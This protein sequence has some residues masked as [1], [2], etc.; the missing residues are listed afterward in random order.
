MPKE[1]ITAEKDIL[2]LQKVKLNWGQILNFIKQK[3]MSVATF[4][5]GAE[6]VRID[7]GNLIIGFGPSSVFHKESLDYNTNRDIVCEAVKTFT[8]ETL[9]VKTEML[10]RDV[11]PDESLPV[12]EIETPEEASSYKKVDPIV[13]AALDKFDGKIASIERARKEKK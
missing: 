8:Q 2:A 1:A 12:E 9:S 10:L 6:P 7:H 13:E 5:Q 4:L 3:K 11:K